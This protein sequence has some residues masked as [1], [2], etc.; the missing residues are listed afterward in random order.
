M[1]TTNEF[2]KVPDFFKEKPKL[3]R[4]VN[5]NPRYANYNQTH[6]TAGDIDQFE[7]YRD[8]TNGK[9]PN[10]ELKSD[11]IWKDM[12]PDNVINDAYKNLTTESVDNTFLYIFNKFKKGIFIKIKDNKLAVFLPFSKHNYINEWGD[13]IKP[14]PEYKTM[15]EFLIY[16]SKIQ[17][18][19]IDESKINKYQNKWYANNCLVRTEFPIGEIDRCVSNL[20]D[21]LLTLC[22]TRSLPDIE[23]FFNRRD[24]PILKSDNSEAYEHIFGNEK[25][26][27]VSHR[28]EKYCPILSMVT[29]DKNLDIPFPTMEDWARVNA[30]KKL[31]APDFRNFSYKF[32]YNWSTKKNIA[33]FRGASTGCGVT[34]ETNPRLKL[35]HMSLLYPDIIDAGITK[36]NCRPRKI[37][38]SEYLQVIDPKNFS[39][40]EIQPLSPEEQ[41]NYKYIID[42]DGHVS[43]F[44]LSLELSMGSVILLQNSKY[45][46]WYRRYL[47]ENV[48]YISIEEDLSN[49]VEKIKWC[50]EHDKECEQIAK[51]AKLFYDT[52]LTEK[53]ILDYAQ[54]LFVNIKKNTGNYFYNYENIQNIVAEK[55]LSILS[56]L[57]TN[58]SYKILESNLPIKY[59]YPRDIN[60]M[61]ALG[62]YLRK[63]KM[64]KLKE[65][66]LIKNITKTKIDNIELCLKKTNNF[67]EAIN[68]AFVGIKCIN[69]LLR[70]IPNF[71]Y[72]FALKND[73]LM[74]EY[75]KGVT[76]QKYI[77]KCTINE[78]L[79]ILQIILLTISVAQER[80]GFVHNDLTPWNIIIKEFDTPQEIIYQFRDCIF[81]VNTKVLPIIIDY[82]KSHVIYEEFHYGFIEPFKT[83]LFQDAFCILITSLYE[84]MKRN[85]ESKVMLYIANF[86]TNTEFCPK[87]FTTI[88]EL[89]DF[90]EKNKKY[91]ELCFCNK[92]DL[93]LYTSSDLFQY[94]FNYSSQNKIETFIYKKNSKSSFHSI[95]I[96]PLF[97][98]NEIIGVDNTNDI[99]EYLDNI[100]KKITEI[101]PKLINNPIRYT[102]SLNMI[103]RILKNL[104]PFIKNDNKVKEITSKLLE[105]N[106]EKYILNIP[107]IPEFVTAKYGIKTFSVP[108][109]ILTILQENTK[110]YDKKSVELLYMLK[111]LLFYENKYELKIRDE[112]K[113]FIK[114]IL[115]LSIINHNANYNTIREISEK[116]YKADKKN[117]EPQT[118]KIIHTI[119]QILLTISD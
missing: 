112:Y 76:F 13:M 10:I 14:P 102:F 68:E 113:K 60:A 36:F 103:D 98:Y 18:Y 1:T 8:K 118:L 85:I 119:D 106:N 108:G 91:N 4:P 64:L 28:Y 58:T 29:T 114:N 49:L 22:E 37:I 99:D 30:G 50:I 35:A 79:S 74:L 33:V 82:G 73:I 2:Q 81:T 6:F 69:K 48:H 11:N 97:Y 31:F 71:M 72:T 55:Q 66:K 87:K 26:P 63:H 59:N 65:E 77:E 42:V 9:Q 67:H 90:L 7:T 100:S 89:Q 34:I 17:G 47:Q 16:A 70:Q 40:K 15:T 83:N 115:P 93:D 61:N 111:S 3:L 23:L 78:F 39:F 46:V 107:V 75:I 80:I 51:N 54:M 95:Y 25:Y 56:M 110:I 32:N 44:R 5:T 116:V 101:L 24:F 96:N 104:A 84:F 27:L 88:I 109:K 21:M 117:L 86:I 45:R 52:F 43:A 62:I 12:I 57:D 19:N 53:G 105:F 38:N 41:S 20:K 92:Y 94:I